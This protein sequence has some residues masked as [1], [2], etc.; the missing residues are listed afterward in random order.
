[1]SDIKSMQKFRSDR[2]RHVRVHSASAV[3]ALDQFYSAVDFHFQSGKL[4]GLCV[5]VRPKAGHH[6]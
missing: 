5:C 2:E 3:D 1:M 6:E 4:G